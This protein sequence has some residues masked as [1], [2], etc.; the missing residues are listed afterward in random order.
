MTGRLLWSLLWAWLICGAALASE[1]NLKSHLVKVEDPGRFHPGDD[2]R[3]AAP[4]LDDSDWAAA[5]LNVS[6]PKQE[7]YEGWTRGW[8]RVHVPVEP[9]VP[10]ALYIFQIR[11]ASELFVDGRLLAVNG[12]VDRGRGGVNMPMAVTVPL[13]LTEDGEL[14]VAARVWGGSWWAQSGAWSGVWTSP[15]GAAHVTVARYYR[16]KAKNPSGYPTVAFG[17]LMILLGLFH[18]VLWLRMREAEQGLFGVAVLLVAGVMVWTALL[19]MGEVPAMALYY[20]TLRFVRHIG[21]IF[22]VAFL[23]RALE[24]PGRVLS[25]L[26]IA[27]L[28]ITGV[29]SLFGPRLPWHYMLFV[30]YPLFALSML[31]VVGRAVYRRQPGGVLMLLGAS[32]GAFLAL[33]ETAHAFGYLG[34]TYRAEAQGWIHLLAMGAMIGSMSALVSLRFARAIEDVERTWQAASRFVPDA[35]LRLLGRNNITE[36]E[37]GDSTSEEMTVMFCA[38]PRI[39]ELAGNW[40]A[41]RS[42]ALLNDLLAELEPLV[43]EHGGIIAQY[44]G[45]GVLALFPSGSTP[46]RAAVAMQAAIQAREPVEGQRLRLVAGMH[47]GPVM[48]GVVGSEGRLTNAQVSDVVNTSARI[49]GLSTHYGAPIVL[50]ESTRALAEAEGLILQELDAVVM[51]GKKVPMRAYEVLGG[52]P[53]LEL[54]RFKEAEAGTYRDA[55]EAFR[56]GRLVEARENFGRLAERWVAAKLFVERCDWFLTH[57]LPHDWDGVVRMTVK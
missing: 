11:D 6:W 35:F 20:T 53:D 17:I 21:L 31:S 44:L 47:T 51:K 27:V 19:E 55:L 40:T 48:L 9:G 16:Y 22:L 56:A 2:P 49:K 5:Q 1:K 37:R 14:V 52:E 38:I 30:G 18:V 28:L 25:R 54:R 26:T 50:S 8:Y 24:H 34:A 12:D 57:G 33:T 42:F 4:D 39:P 43:H 29:W 41:D 46:V 36:V 45:D 7:G 13:E 15:P 3:W 10:V 32:P 23:V